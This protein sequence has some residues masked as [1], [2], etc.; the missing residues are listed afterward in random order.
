MEL[1]VFPLEAVNSVPRTSEGELNWD[2]ET[3]AIWSGP[4]VRLIRLP[5]AFIYLT[6]YSYMPGRISVS[7]IHTDKTENECH[8]RRLRKLRHA[9]S[10]REGG[11]PAR[12]RG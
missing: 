2:A 1:G 9:R 7:I 4:F 8:S 6:Q 11:E 5:L 3:V 12:L 10:H